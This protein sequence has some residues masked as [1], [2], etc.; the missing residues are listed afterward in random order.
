MNGKKTAIIMGGTSGIGREVAV[1]LAQTGEWQVAVCGRNE[2]QLRELQDTHSH[3][4][5]GRRIDVTDGDA[6]AQ[7]MQLISD[8]GGVDLYFHSSGIGWQ[9]PDLDVEKELCTVETNA[10]GFC[11]MATAV[12]NYTAEHP[13]RRLQLA[14]ISSIAG[15]QGLGA[16]PAYSATKRFVNHY[17]EC[18]EQLRRMRGIRNLTLCDIRPGFVRTPLIADSRRYPMQL[19]APGVARAII[20][21]LASNRRIITIDWRY[22]LLVFFWQLLPV[23]L[24]VRLPVRS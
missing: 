17:M 6:P 4:V 14:V 16:A 9:N 22:R 19:E 7:L 1:Q 11:R 24:W 15:T 10:L 21:G 23:W 3:I 5:A 18:L 8:L 20:Q 12:F 13:E 2:A